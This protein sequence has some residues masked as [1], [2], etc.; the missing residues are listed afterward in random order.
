MLNAEETWY[1]TK[2]VEFSRVQISV[3]LFAFAPL[4]SNTPYMDVAS[5]AALPKFTGVCVCVCIY[6]CVCVYE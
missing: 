3:D 5:L 6:L 4:S 2:A 1:R